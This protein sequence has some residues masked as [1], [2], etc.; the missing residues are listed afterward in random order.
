MEIIRFIGP[1][2]IISYGHHFENNQAIRLAG[3]DFTDL[4][5][6]GER[7]PVETLLSPV[8]PRAIFCIGLNYRAHA[9]EVGMEL[10]PHPALFMKSPASVTAHGTPVIIPTSCQAKPEVDYEVELAVILGKPGKNIPVDQALDHVFAYTCAN[11]ISAR[12]WQK[13]AGA[14]QWVKSKSFDTFCPLGPAMV[15]ADEIPDPQDLNLSLKLNGET[16]Q[17]S[18]TSD[19]IFTIAEIISFLSQDA[20]LLPGSVI[21]TG[22]PSGVGYTRNP[23]VFIQDGDSMEVE[24]QNIG[25]LINT[26][27]SA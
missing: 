26:V 10:P 3:N 4:K 15:T 2:Q 20:T 25:R 22:T 23:R 7:V 11:D 24:I 21:L 19:M 1:D 18:H 14:G 8:D 6:T 5:D 9:A 27:Q 17:E 13:H 16:M 12:R